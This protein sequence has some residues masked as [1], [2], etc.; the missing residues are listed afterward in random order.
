MAR[1]LVIDDDAASRAALRRLLAQS[2]YEVVE[3]A[4]G[5]EGLRCMVACPPDVLLLDIFMP[6]QDGIEI[7]RR[8]RHSFP[9]VPIV[10]MSG[11]SS[12]REHDVLTAA[13]DFGA[14]ATFTKPFAPDA[15]L[16]TLQAVIGG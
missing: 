10:A 7:I 13:R 1:I 3:A 4:T 5:Y 11:G 9:H 6:D 8:V 14:R 12:Y 15:L 2:G 16:A